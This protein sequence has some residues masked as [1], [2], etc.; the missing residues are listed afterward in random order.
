MTCRIKN[1][2]NQDLSK[3]T[4][5]TNEFYPYAKKSMGFDKEAT[6]VFESDLQNAQN[7]LGK[8]AYYDPRSYTVTI[9]IDKRHPKDIMRSV[10]HELVHHDQN[11]MGKFENIGPTEEGYA[12]SDPYLRKMEEDAYRRGNLCFRDWENQKN[13]MR[14]NKKVKDLKSIVKNVLAERNRKDTPDR[15]NKQLPPDRLKPLE[16]EEEAIEEDKSEVESGDDVVESKEEIDEL[17]KPELEEAASEKVEAD[18]E[19]SEEAEELEEADDW[20]QSTEKGDWEKPP[21]KPKKPKKQKKQNRTGEESV[22]NLKNVSH[23]E[24]DETEVEGDN[25]PLNEWYN[26]SIFNKLL[27]EYTKR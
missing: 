8:T 1:N 5:M 4:Q 15:V 2:S 11:C 16:E 3:I 10:S 13:Q 24:E 25:K 12:Q 6:I 22:I 18:L 9:Y 14:E 20:Y 26:D 19:E 17:E 7:P 21:E 23:L 27:K